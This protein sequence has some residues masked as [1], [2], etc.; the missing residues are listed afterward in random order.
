MGRDWRCGKARATT[1]ITART[2]AHPSHPAARVY[3]HHVGSHP[4]LASCLHVG[5]QVVPRHFREEEARTSR[6]CVTAPCP[7]P[8]PTLPTLT[9]RRTLPAYRTPPPSCCS[10]FVALPYSSTPR[11]LYHNLLIF[12]VLQH[13]SSVL[14]S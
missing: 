6:S 3:E 8:I 11:A 5:C 7:S 14:L 13:I 1:T 4:S 9:A 12:A 2:T 10:S